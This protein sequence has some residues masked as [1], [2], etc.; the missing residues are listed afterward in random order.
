MANAIVRN[1]PFFINNSK[2]GEQMEGD[3]D[4]DA[5]MTPQ[6]GDDQIAYA[7][8]RQTCTLSIKTFMP[9]Q[10]TKYKIDTIVE[11][12]QDIQAQFIFN[13]KLRTVIGVLSG[14]GGKWDAAKGTYEGNWKLMGTLSK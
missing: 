14:M 10:G 13:G 4:Y 6:Y 2:I 5:A 1:S 11:A 12:Q 9:V 3:F 8:G 7:R